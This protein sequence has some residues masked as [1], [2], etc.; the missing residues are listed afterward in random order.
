MLYL[1]GIVDQG[2]PPEFMPSGFEN[3][4]A[5][6]V[7]F[8]GFAAITGSLR[9]G[10]PPVTEVHLR[11]HFR[12][13]EA[14]MDWHT[15][16]PARFGSIFAGDGELTAY[17]EQ[18]RDMLARDLQ[19]LR[20]QIELGV[21]A[22]WPATARA[23]DGAAAFT[24][25]KAGPGARYLAERR[26]K[27]VHRLER[28]REAR[29]LAAQI[30]APLGLHATQ[31]EWRPIPAASGDVCVSMAFLLPRERLEA[32]REA[33]AALR[34]AR[35]GLDIL[36]TGPWPPYSFVSAFDQTEFRPSNLRDSFRCR[37]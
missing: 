37:V 26:A 31:V 10:R 20:G 2:Q 22:A 12:V 6:I 11:L 23:S 7:P 24:T 32:F 29:D 5:S 16:L 17:V 30:S 27:A 8:D 25:A 14:L 28:Q 35:P 9:S 13:L 21:K 4:R 19:R 18:M 34:V 3:S 1:Y 36:C 33:L 15:V